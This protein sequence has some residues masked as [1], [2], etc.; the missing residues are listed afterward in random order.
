M[1]PIKA[2]GRDEEKRQAAFVQHSHQRDGNDHTG[3]RGP[4]RAKLGL[5]V[6]SDQAAPAVDPHHLA[7]H[8]G[9]AHQI[10]IGPGRLFNGSAAQQGL[11]GLEPTDIN[12]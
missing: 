12:N 9:G 11:V 5:A 1:R 10:E 7:G 3:H 8:I 4:A 6:N 2:P